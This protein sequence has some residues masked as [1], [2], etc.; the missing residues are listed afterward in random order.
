ML[1][2]M[3]NNKSNANVIAN[4]FG[5]EFYN[6]GMLLFLAQVYVGIAMKF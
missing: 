5:K 6:D 2:D 3:T 1:V 4:D